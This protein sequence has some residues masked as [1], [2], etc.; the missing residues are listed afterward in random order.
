MGV[1]GGFGDGGG[2]GGGGVGGGV[3]RE[4]HDAAAAHIDEAIGRSYI[5]NCI[6]KR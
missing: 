6:T 1:G 2:G 5:K 4:P 3:Y